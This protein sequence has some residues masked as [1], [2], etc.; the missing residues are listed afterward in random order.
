MNAVLTMSFAPLAFFLHYSPF[1][2]AG[3]VKYGG[4]HGNPF[5]ERA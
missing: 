1:S 4:F 3:Q 5:Y 2:R